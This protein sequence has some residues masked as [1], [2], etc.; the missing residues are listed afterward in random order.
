MPAYQR[1]K[2]GR[3]RRISFW[4][5]WRQRRRGWGWEV[6]MSVFGKKGRGDVFSAA[7]QCNYNI[8]TDVP[9]EVEITSASYGNC[10]AC[11]LSHYPTQ[12]EDACL[13]KGPERDVYISSTRPLS[14]LFSLPA[15][16]P[17]VEPLKFVFGGGQAQ[18]SSS[19]MHQV[20]N[21][22]LS[23][24]SHVILKNFRR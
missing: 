8:S 19:I 20:P 10:L 11:S 6:H 21:A 7:W 14:L 2:R 16:Q 1:Q 17:W 12:R 22:S 9:P 18:M 15:S 23:V 13:L 3:Q 5:G 4:S 24:I